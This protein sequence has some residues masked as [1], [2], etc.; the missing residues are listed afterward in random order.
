MRTADVKLTPDKVPSVLAKATA[1]SRPVGK[2]AL[3]HAGESSAR[4]K[5]ANRLARASLMH[6]A[7]EH[8]A[9]GIGGTTHRKTVLASLSLQDSII[10]TIK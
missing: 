1:F 7:S 9:I 5:V 8:V 4:P 3:G 2:P 6:F 10:V